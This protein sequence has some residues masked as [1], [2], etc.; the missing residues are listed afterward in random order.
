MNA[1]LDR[2]RHW[3]RVSFGFLTAEA[4]QWLPWEWRRVN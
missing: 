1:P 4:T 2:D 3:R